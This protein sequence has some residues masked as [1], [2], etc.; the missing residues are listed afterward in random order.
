M[1]LKWVVLLEEMLM[2][3]GNSIFNPKKTLPNPHDDLG[4]LTCSHFAALQHSW[5]QNYCFPVQCPVSPAMQRELD[6]KYLDHLH[7]G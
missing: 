4:C 6:P 7:F 2:S 5:S 1:L 3:V